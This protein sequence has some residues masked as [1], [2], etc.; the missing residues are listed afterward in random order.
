MDLHGEALHRRLQR[1][2]AFVVPL[3]AARRVHLLLALRVDLHTLEELADVVVRRVR[4][5][6]RLLVIVPLQLPPRIQHGFRFIR[7]ALH[8][9]FLSSSPNSNSEIFGTFFV[10]RF[11]FLRAPFSIEREYSPLG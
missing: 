7:G 4:V 3:V 5:R 2:K 8:S 11:G 10:L 1:G 6:P 9:A